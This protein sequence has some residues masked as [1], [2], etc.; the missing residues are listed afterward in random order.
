MSFISKKTILIPGNYLVNITGLVSVINSPVVQRLR[1]V[2]QLGNLFRMFPG[3]V[4]TRFEHSLGCLFWTSKIID[5]L[6]LDDYSSKILRLYSVLHDIGHGP[7]SHEIE[8]LLNDNHNN[9][10]FDRISSIKNE[11]AE[12]GVDYNDLIA[13]ARKPS[14]LIDIVRD[15]N[16]GSDKLDY[17]LRD[18]LHIGFIGAPD[19]VSLI[20]N[21]L[22]HDK[23][24]AIDEKAVEDI[25]RFQM[26]YAYLHKNGYL[27]KTSIMIERMFSRSVQE[28]LVEDPEIADIMWNLTDID[29]ESLILKSDN[30]VSKS[31]YNH[32]YNRK[33]YLSSVILRLSAYTYQE[34]IANKPIAVFGLEARAINR[35]FSIYSDISRNRALENQLSGVLGIPEGSLLVAFSPHLKRLLPKDVKLYCPDSSEILSLEKS[36]PQHYEKLNSEYYSSLCIRVGSAPKYRE[37]LFRKADLI[38]DNIINL[39]I[40]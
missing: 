23:Q 3:A 22:I 16:I 13:F 6:R 38:A 9:I 14:P 27:N 1:Y 24:Y 34:R 40:D 19:P 37:L 39:N 28:L 8:P 33:I 10:F 18:S 7:F 25:K 4:H 31:I 36:D 2:K 17:M 26:F 15:R 32:L 5:H 12:T 20:E 30:S 35:L 29:A 11:I 21:T